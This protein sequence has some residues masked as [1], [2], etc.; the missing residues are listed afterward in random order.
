MFLRLL[1]V[2]VFLSALA[3]QKTDRQGRQ[4]AANEHSALSP[5]D[6]N[7]T[8]TSIYLAPLPVKYDFLILFDG[9]DSVAT[10]GGKRFPTKANFDFMAYF[11]LKGSPEE[12]YLWVNHET[13]EAND[14]LGDGGGACILRIKRQNETWKRMGPPKA[15]DF[16]SVGG[17]WNNCLGGPTPWGTVLTSEEYEPASNKEIY[18]QGKGIRDTAVYGGFPKYLNYGWMVEADPYSGKVLGKRWALGRFSHEGALCMPDSQTIYLLDDFAPGIFFKFVAE[19]KADLSKGRLFALQ[20]GPDGKSVR[21]LPLPSQRDSLNE[22]RKVALRRGASFFIRLEDIE[23]LPDGRFVLSETGKDEADLA[24]A[25]KLGGKPAPHLSK[26]HK[27]NGKYNDYYGRLLVYDPQKETLEVFLEGGAGKNSNVHFANP[28]NL[29]VNP[30]RNW[31]IIHEDINAPS[32]G[33]VSPKAGNRLVNEI[34]IL[35]LSLKNPTIDKLQLLLIAPQ[36][37]ETTGSCW[38]SDYST[39]FINV[40][41]PDPDNPPPFNKDMTIAVYGLAK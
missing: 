10:E 22:I 41:H 1:F 27:G 34:Y 17:T 30:V 26:Y 9:E 18:K 14:N 25:L 13:A 40:Q 15:V 38:D 8:S 21:W 5:I 4:I 19:K 36:G 33:R 31:L 3:C 28:D 11:P 7:F 37:A 35:D 12:G 2:V 24:W 39:L 32:Q 6:T 16:A 29:S 20:I 23:R